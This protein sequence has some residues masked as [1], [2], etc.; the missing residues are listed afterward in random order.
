MTRGDQTYARTLGDPCFIAPA[1]DLGTSA[2]LASDDTLSVPGAGDVD[3]VERRSLV[4]RKNTDA[5]HHRRDVD[6]DRVEFGHLPGQARTPDRRSTSDQGGRRQLVP[7]SQLRLPEHRAM[8]DMAYYYNTDR[9]HR[10]WDA[11]GRGAGRQR[12]RL[13]GLPLF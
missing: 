13:E 2:T 9:R 12:N 10:H 1:Y 3:N 5:D 4:Q 7:L 8:S 11:H 6:P